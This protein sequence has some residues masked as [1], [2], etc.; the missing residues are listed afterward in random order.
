MIRE[1]ENEGRIPIL[2]VIVDS[3]MAAEA[4]RIYHRR[5]EEHD[6]EYSAIIASSS[7]PLR[8]RSMQTTAS[9]DESKRVN[10]IEGSRIIISASGM[11][12]GGRVLHHAMRI[13]PD[14]NATLVFAGYQ[15]AGTR[16]RRIQNGEREIKVMKTW[17]PVRCHIE[18]IEGYS[19]HADWQGVLNWLSGLTEAPKL[20]FTTHGEPPAAA[21]MAEH[22]RERFGW[23]V[24]VPEYGE[25]VE[26]T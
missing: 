6:Q 10:R 11:L 16:G 17:V 21:A 14:R 20:V 1:L 19:A 9:R 8:T 12:S 24:M 25:T 23:P 15:A 3:P 2:P 13:L 26:L 7:H 4:T 18:N 5:L 22:I